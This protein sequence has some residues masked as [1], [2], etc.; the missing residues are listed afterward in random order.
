MGALIL[1]N[2]LDGIASMSQQRD[3][4]DLAAALA[5]VVGQIVASD[6]VSLYRNS[7]WTALSRQ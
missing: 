2:S 5:E 3:Q 1:D 7:L 4:R 6:D